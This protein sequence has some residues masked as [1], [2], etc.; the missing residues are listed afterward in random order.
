M[1][2]PL[3]FSLDK[4]SSLRGVSYEWDRVSFPDRNFP[5]GKQIGLIA[6]EVEDII[7]EVV[8]TDNEGYKSLAYDRLVAVLVEAVKEQKDLVY[9][10]RKRIESLESR[11]GEL[12]SR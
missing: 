7:P 1:S 12:E 8:S 2:P 11:I 10:H 6:Q 4:V 5:E 3:T 9:E